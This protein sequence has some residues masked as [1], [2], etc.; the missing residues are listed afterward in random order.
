MRVAVIGESKGLVAVVDL[1]R[2]VNVAENGE[3]LV[4]TP[5]H[6]LHVPRTRSKCI[7]PLVGGFETI[8]FGN[9]IN[10]E[11]SLLRGDI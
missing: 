9:K 7:C 1:L 3:K 10:F 4:S 2:V 11:Q 8:F 5:G 6:V